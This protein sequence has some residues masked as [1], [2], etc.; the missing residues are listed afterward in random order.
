[1]DLSGTVYSDPVGEYIWLDCKKWFSKY[2]FAV[3]DRICIK[4]F[5]SILSTP[6]TQDIMSY[7]QDED[8][9]SIAGVAWARNITDTEKA[10]DIGDTSY[11]L[12]SGVKGSLAQSVLLDGCN[13][14]GYA[15]FIILRG[16]FTDP[17]TGSTAVNPYGGA[18][19]NSAVSTAIISGSTKITSGK[20]I[21]MS[22]QTQLIFRVIT[23]EYDS[24][25]LV[26]PDNL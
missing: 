11:S 21:N 26:R 7:L 24:T 20:L 12:T 8:G 4:N 5:K 16:K 9:L 13:S 22:R 25:S 1:M 18:T 17:S 15:R 19:D 3:G 14:V 6:A 23:R 10:R 2:Q